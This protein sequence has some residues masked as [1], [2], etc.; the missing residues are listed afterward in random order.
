MI[1]HYKLVYDSPMYVF[2]WEFVR[3]AFLDDFGHFS[4]VA[5]YLWSILLYDQIVMANNILQKSRIVRQILHQWF[6]FEILPLF[7]SEVVC[8]LLDQFGDVSV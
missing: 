2:A 3:I 7:I 1:V 4:E 6:E 5:G 8:C